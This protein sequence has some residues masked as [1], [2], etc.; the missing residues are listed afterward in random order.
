MV[1]RGID[2]ELRPGRRLAVVGPS[3]VGK[4]TLLLTLAGLLEPRAG[5]LTLNGVAPWGAARQEVAAQVTLTAEDAHVFDTTVL[6]NLRVARGDVTA[7]QATALLERAGLGPWLA[8]LPQGLD[9]PVSSDAATLAGGER[10]RL[11]LA[12]ALACP[13]PL[14]LL[15]EPGEH[16]DA[17]TADRLVADLLRAGAPGTG[18]DGA[19]GTGDDGAAG[20]GR[21]T[22]LVTHRLS[23]LG[24]AEEVLVLGRTGSGPATIV[25]RGSHADLMSADADYRWTVSQEQSDD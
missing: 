11:L 21:G 24:H 9:T 10:R 23:A 5:T 16:L 17:G 15:D 13:A 7:S 2:L 20:D 3:G 1:A 4:T 25:R 22:L 8:C 14:M 18:D 12:R 19:P 6:E